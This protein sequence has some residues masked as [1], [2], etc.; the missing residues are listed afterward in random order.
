MYFK[1]VI[2]QKDIKIHLIEECKAG[3]VPHAQLFAG[4]EGCG[5][6][7]LAMDFA[8]Y[9]LTEN[10]CN[11]T[12][13]ENALAMLSN[14]EHPD[15]HFTYPTIKLPGMGS[16]HKP[17]SDDFSVEPLSHFF[18]TYKSFGKLKILTIV[19]NLF[20]LQA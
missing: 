6:M 14:W 20:R 7:A 19:L 3:R 2:G 11:P 13:H 5:K 4:P 10:I 18:Q 1:D 12:A 9:L 16:D 8:K 15:L 17:I